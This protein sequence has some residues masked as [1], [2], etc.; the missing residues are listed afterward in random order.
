MEWSVKLRSRLNTLQTSSTLRSNVISCK[1][2][3]TFREGP[4]QASE[5]AIVNPNAT[6]NVLCKYP[7][8]FIVLDPPVS[9]HL[10]SRIAYPE[11]PAVETLKL[12]PPNPANQ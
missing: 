12:S 4:C 3:S 8:G 10:P 5:Q 9:Q 6:A 2:A 11:S 1:L 7:C